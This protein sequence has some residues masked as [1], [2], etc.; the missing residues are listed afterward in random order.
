MICHRVGVG[1]AF[2][3]AG[4]REVRVETQYNFGLSNLVPESDGFNVRNR[5]FDFLVGIAL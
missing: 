2:D 1:A 4:G 3:V 5:G